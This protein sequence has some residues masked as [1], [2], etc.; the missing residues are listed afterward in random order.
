MYRVLSEEVIRPSARLWEGRARRA[1]GEASTVGVFYHTT[2]GVD[3]FITDI[4]VPKMGDS[5]R[6]EMTNL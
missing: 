2:E 3:I 1:V 5:Q 4:L 6:P